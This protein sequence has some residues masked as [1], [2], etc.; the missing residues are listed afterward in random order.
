M[1]KIISA[2]E[3]HAIRASLGFHTHALDLDEA[4]AKYAEIQQC[5][6]DNVFNIINPSELY[7][8]HEGDAF[9][10]SVEEAKNSFSMHLS[11]ILQDAERG[12]R[13]LAANDRLDSDARA[14]DLE[15]AALIGLN[16]KQTH[17]VD[18]ATWKLDAGLCFWAD[19]ND[20]RAEMDFEN[21]LPRI[22]AQG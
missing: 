21:G 3:F 22:L 19:E 16:S 1:N 13:I 10:D 7:E 17:K 20:N 6:S 14:W 12:L 9:C 8:H 15:R 2:L 11:D 4:Q 5:D 18:G